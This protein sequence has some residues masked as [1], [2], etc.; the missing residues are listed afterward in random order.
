M[1]RKDTLENMQAIARERNG[2]CLS[3]TYVDQRTPLRWQC[4]EGHAWDAIPSIIKGSRNKRGTWCRACGIRAAAK[5]RRYKLE[6]VQR[7]AEE[8]GGALASDEY[9]GS[10][11]KHR[12]RC[13]QY[14]S[15]PEF[16]MIPNAVQQGQWCPACSGNIKPTLKALND[17]A[18][19]KHPL[20]QCTSSLYVNS[21]TPLDWQCGIVGH[22][23]FIRAY[24]SVKY[25]GAWCDLCRRER[26]R[27]RKYDRDLLGGFAAK[28]GGGL[29]SEEPYRS[30]K[31]VLRWRCADGHEFSR[32]L[33]SILS[34]GSFC[35]ECTKRAGLREQYVREV[36]S[37]MFAA[38]FE[39]RRDLDWLINQRGNAME[40]D[41]FNSDLSLA[42]EHNGQQHYQLDGFFTTHPEQLKSRLAD[43]AEKL[44][45]CKATGIALIVVPFFR[46]APQR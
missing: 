7:M 21:S 40:L 22:P 6:D 41:G 14:P 4:A 30:T 17:L 35:P 42:F 27:P 2:R 29:V 24:K 37:H 31:Q 26:P 12:W 33:D 5:K 10:Q 20:A 44:R 38:P 36:F 45:L 28:V 16:Q 8:H 23:P 1:S 9:M 46:P 43:D 34:Y 25:D 39:R 32:S 15:H 11:V 18:R 13:R 3:T 19:R